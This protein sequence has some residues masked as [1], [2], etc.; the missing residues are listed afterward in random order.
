[1]YE[2]RKLKLKEYKKQYRQ[3]FLKKK[4]KKNKEYISLKDKN[5]D[6]DYPHFFIMVMIL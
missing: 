4:S 1:M 5:N 3:I 6:I 2:E